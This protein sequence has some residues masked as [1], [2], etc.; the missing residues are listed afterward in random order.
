MNCSA[1]GAARD[2]STRQIGA[3]RRRSQ[4]S[5]APSR[6]GASRSRDRRVV[7]VEPGDL[8]GAQQRRVDAARV[9]RAERQRLELEELAE[10]AADAAAPAR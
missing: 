4:A 8:V 6:R 7:G 3:V 1:G 5:A 2:A 10:L 9:D